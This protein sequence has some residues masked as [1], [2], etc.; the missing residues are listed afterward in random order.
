MNVRRESAFN[1]F[2]VLGLI[3]ALS[4]CAKHRATRPKAGTAAVVEP[5]ADVVISET[6]PPM[7][8]EVIVPAPGP[9][10]V[11]IPG[12]WSWVGSWAWVRG[13]W[14]IPPYPHA[15]YV[16]GHWSHRGHGY[17]WFSGHWR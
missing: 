7:Q 3:A 9:G 16:P 5:S 1:V 17:V 8:Q 14:V 6:P 2:F 15:T 12:Y 13:A 4:G 10:Y 11:W